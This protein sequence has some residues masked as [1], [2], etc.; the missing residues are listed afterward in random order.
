MRRNIQTPISLRVFVGMLVFLFAATTANAATLQQIKDRGFINIAVANEMP[1]GYLAGKD[2]AEGFGPSTARQVLAD[3]G[4]NEIHWSAVEF[5]QLISAVNSGQ[6]DM[7]AA[8]QAIEPERCKQ[9]LFSRPNTS[10]GEGLLVRAGN[11]KDLHSYSD[12]ADDKQLRLGVVKGTTEQQFAPTAGVGNKQLV[13]LDANTDAAEALTSN[14]IDAYAGTQFSVADIADKNR[15]VSV[16]QPYPEK[17]FAWNPFTDP[18]AGDQKLRSWGAFTFAKKDAA[19]RDAFDQHLQAFQ[20]TRRWR[21]ILAR[22]GLDERSIDAIDKKT[23]AE[24]C[25]DS[26]AAE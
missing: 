9:V 12:I 5:G 15:R 3:M 7:V 14:R 1:Y 18:V 19:L 20:Q 10:Y 22:Y 6:V 24:L 25:E 23:T 26:A 16:A 17:P 8:S 2:D 4:I 11:P 21:D 13:A